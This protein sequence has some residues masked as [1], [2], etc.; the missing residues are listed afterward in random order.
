MDDTRIQ[1]RRGVYDELVATK[2]AETI[3]AQVKLTGISRA[4]LWRLRRGDSPS[5]PSAIRIADALGVPVDY[6][7]ERVDA[8]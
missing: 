7:F 6:L 3:T 1:L 4:T 5:L 8:S 2:G